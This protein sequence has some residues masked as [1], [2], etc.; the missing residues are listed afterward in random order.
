MFRLQGKPAL[1]SPSK[2]A[3]Q[4]KKRGDSEC[5]FHVFGANDVRDQIIELTRSRRR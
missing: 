4:V 3:V 2:D 1:L 5:I